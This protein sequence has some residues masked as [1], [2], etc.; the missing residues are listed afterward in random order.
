[1]EEPKEKQLKIPLKNRS[2]NVSKMKYFELIE[3]DISKINEKAH[4]TSEQQQVFDMLIDREYGI[5][6]CDAYIYI[7]LGMSQSKFYRKKKQIGKKIERIIV[8]S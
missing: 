8:D 1:M 3:S 5:N 7:T 4:W 2:E 6:Y